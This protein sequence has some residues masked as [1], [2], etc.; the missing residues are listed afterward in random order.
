MWWSHDLWPRRPEQSDVGLETWKW[1]RYNC[2]ATSSLCS[3][4]LTSSWCWAAFWRWSSHFTRSGRI[5]STNML[6]VKY[7]FRWC[8]LWVC[9]CCDVSDCSELSKWPGNQDRSVRKDKNIFIFTRLRWNLFKS[10]SN[11][12][13]LS[14]TKEKSLKSIRRVH[15]KAIKEVEISSNG[16]K[17]NYTEAHTNETL[18]GSAKEQILFWNHFN[19]KFAK[20]HLPSLSSSHFLILYF[21][22]HLWKCK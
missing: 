5:W 10:N 1:C 3:T 15:L 2:R 18:I 19:F 11:L 4:G 16:G 8:H 9:P 20:M 14:W 12:F 21:L 22:Y 17:K 7:Y 13:L 6:N